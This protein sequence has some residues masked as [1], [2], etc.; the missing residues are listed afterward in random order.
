[1]LPVAKQGDFNDGEGQPESLKL[2][3]MGATDRLPTEV[4]LID[5]AETQVPTPWTDEKSFR[6]K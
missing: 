4:G 1:M 3:F 5:E 2:G 6:R